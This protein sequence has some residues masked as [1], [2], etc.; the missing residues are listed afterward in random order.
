MTPEPFKHHRDAALTLLNRFPDLS[1]R[2]AGFL[3]HACV[4]PELSLK[5][6][7]WLDGLLERRELP[8]LVTGGRP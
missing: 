4:E 3:G 6:R 5:Q 1:H 2:E 7:N 8:P